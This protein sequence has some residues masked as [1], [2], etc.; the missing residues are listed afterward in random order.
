MSTYKKVARHPN[1]GKWERATFHDDY[2]APHVYGVEF[3][4]DGKVYTIEMLEKTEL[5]EFWADDVI[6]AFSIFMN[7]YVGEYDHKDLI[8]FLDNIDIQYHARWRDDPQGGG[9][10]VEYYRKKFGKKRDVCEAPVVVE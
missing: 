6:E 9:G 2:F 5:K 1:T 10:A 4:S 7:D 8:T 3:P